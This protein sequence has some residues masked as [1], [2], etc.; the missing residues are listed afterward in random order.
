M[1]TPIIGHQED[2]GWQ[3]RAMVIKNEGDYIDE[4][5]G[6]DFHDEGDDHDH[7]DRNPDGVE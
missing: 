4:G 6:E 1:M 2:E 3:A 5:G 7:E